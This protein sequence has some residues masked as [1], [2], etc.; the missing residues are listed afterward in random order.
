MTPRTALLLLPFSLAAC[1]KSPPVMHPTPVPAP[2]IPALAAK[3][4]GETFG[5]VRARQVVRTLERVG[6]GALVDQAR[7]RGIDPAQ[8]D[9]E[10]PI[11]AVAGDPGSG[12]WEKLPIA[13]LI[14]VAPGSPLAALL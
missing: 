14:P 8:I 6:A 5:W 4:D 7:G 1:V 3:P 11:V 10:R 12:G 2:A 9:P 13:A